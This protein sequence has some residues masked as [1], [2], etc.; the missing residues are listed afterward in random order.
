MQ[1]NKL[2]DSGE[3]PQQRNI[4]PSGSVTIENNIVQMDTEDAAAKR[5]KYIKWGIIG[6]VAL[7]AVVLAIVL[8]LTLGGGGNDNGG[9]GPLPP[10]QMNPYGAVAGTAK[11]SGS[12]TQF[13]GSLV[14]ADI[15][16]V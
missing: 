7:I 4:N 10:G 9:H 13:T 8:P 2:E 5:K 11:Y 1:Y 6:A 15:T 16:K 3:T 14:S 12:G